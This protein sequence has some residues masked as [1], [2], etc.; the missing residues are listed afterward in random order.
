MFVVCFSLN[1]LQIH[2][3]HSNLTG[4]VD[5]FQCHVCN[6]SYYCSAGVRYPCP[7]NSLAIE[8]ADQLQEC[9]CNPGYVAVG[10]GP[11]RQ[12][13]PTFTYDF[14]SSLFPACRHCPNDAQFPFPQYAFDMPLRLKLWLDYAASIGATTNINAIGSRVGNYDD[15]GFTGVYA[16]GQATPP[17][18][19]FFRLR[20]SREY[21]RVTVIY[22]AFKQYI[23]LYI[24]DVLQQS[25]GSPQINSWSTPV[26]QECIYTTAYSPGSILELRG[27]GDVVFIGENLKFLF[28]HPQIPFACDLGLSPHWYLYGQ[29]NTCPANK[30]VVA[31][32]S[33]SVEDCVCLPGY[34]SQGPSV[35]TACLPCPADTYTKGSN[36]SQCT[37]CPGNSS[38]TSTMQTDISACLCNAGWAGIAATGCN[39]CHVDF[40]SDRNSLNC[41]HCPPGTATYE[42]PRASCQ[43]HAGY[44]PAYQVTN[45]ATRWYSATSESNIVQLRGEL[46]SPPAL[47][48]PWGYPNNKIYLSYGWFACDACWCGGGACAW[49]IIDL[50]KIE[51]VAGFVIQHSCDGGTKCGQYVNRVQVQYSVVQDSGFIT[52][53][54]S[55]DGGVDFYPNNHAAK[56]YKNT[57]DKTYQ[58]FASPVRARYIRLNPMLPGVYNSAFF[59]SGVIIWPNLECSSCRMNT[60]KNYTGTRSVSYDRTALSECQSCPY[61]SSTTATNSTSCSCNAGAYTDTNSSDASVCRGCGLGMYLSNSTCNNC[62]DNTFASEVNTQMCTQC[63]NASFNHDHSRSFCLCKSGFISDIV[64]VNPPDNMRYFSQELLGAY[65]GIQYSESRL[66]TIG[67]QAGWWPALHSNAP[68]GTWLAMDLGVVRRVYGVVIQSPDNTGGCGGSLVCPTAISVEYSHFRDTGF[69][70]AKNLAT[71]NTMFYPVDIGET[72]ECLA[73][74]G[75][76]CAKRRSNNIFMEPVMTRYV[77]IRVWNWVYRI[78]M[79]AGVLVVSDTCSPCPAN[80]YKEY[81][82]TSG[83]TCDACQPN[84]VSHPGS[85][86]QSQCNCSAG[87]FKNGSTL[88]PSCAGGYYS[89][90]QDVP[91]CTKCPEHTF[92]DPAL[93]P[94]DTASDCRV[95]KLCNTSTNAAFTDHYDAARG[96][97]GCG[98]SSVEVCTQCPSRSSLFLP[99]TESQRNLGVSSC[100]CDADFY[101]NVGT[102]CTACPANQV[103]PNLTNVNTTLADCLCTAGFEPNASAANLCTLCPVGSYKPYTGDDMCTACAPTFTTSKVGTNNASGCVCQPGYVYGNDQ[104]TICPENM[105]KA[106]FNLDTTCNACTANSFGPAGGTVPWDCSCS[107]NHEANPLLC[108]PCKTGKYKN[109]STTIGLSNQLFV[110]SQIKNLARTCSGGP[111]PTQANGYWDGETRFHPDRAVDGDISEYN[112]FLSSPQHIGSWL[113]I[114]MQQSVSVTMVRIYNRKSC[115][116][117]CLNNF[118]IR[119]GDLTFNKQNIAQN[120]ACVT[121]GPHFVDVKD[122]PCVLK[123]RWFT[124]QIFTECGLGIRE[125]EIYGTKEAYTYESANEWKTDV[126]ST[127]TVLGRCSACPQNTATNNTGVLACEACAAGK[128]TDRR[129]G[130]VECVC[131]VGTEHGTDGECVTCPAGRYK[132]TSTDKYAN[133]ACVNCSSCAANQ[134]VATLCNATH[135]V[136]CR[137]CQANS[138]SYAGRTELG[139]CLCNAGYELQGV[140]CVACAV[141]KARQVNNSNSIVCETCGAG[142]FT[143]VSA[144]ITCGVCSDICDKPC[145]EKIFDFSPYYGVAAWKAAA[146]AWG[147][148]HRLF[149]QSGDGFGVAGPSQAGWVQFGLPGNSPPFNNLEVSFYSTGDGNAL[150]Y[151]DDQLKASAGAYGSSMFPTVY[152]QVG[153]ITGTLKLLESGSGGIGRALKITLRRNCESYVKN[154]CNASRDVIC[155]ECQTCGLGFYANNTCGVNHS[156]DRLDTQCAACPAGY[157]CPGGRVAISC[158]DNRCAANQQVAT[159]CNTTH[160]VTCKACQANSWSYAGRTE[161]GPC[162]CNAGYELQGVL[163]IACPVG[164]AR[165]ANANNSIVCE[166]CA[167]GTFTSVSANITCSTCSKCAGNQQV[168]TLCNATHNVTCK[169][170]QANSWSYAGSTE[171]GP[172]LCNAGY[173]LQGVLCIACPVGK[174]RQ[175]NYN[176]SIMCET[177]ASGTLTT[178]TATT[179][180][181]SCSANCELNIPL[182]KK[183]ADFTGTYSTT[184]YYSTTFSGDSRISWLAYANSIGA[185]YFNINGEG[186]GGVF[187]NFGASGITLGYIEFTLPSGYSFVEIDA[188][189]RGTQELYISGVRYACNSQ[190]KVIA[191]YI[192]GDK[193]RFSEEWGVITYAIK[194]SVFRLPSLPNYVQQE[195]NA[196]RDVICQECQTCGVG[197]FANNTCGANYSNGR[198]DTQCAVC[199]AGS[200]C[201]TGLGPPI[202]CPNNGQSLPGS[203]SDDACDCDPGYFR[204]VDGCKQC[205]L[206]TYCPGEQVQHAISCPPMSRTIARGSTMRMDCHCQVGYFRDPPS[207]ENSFNCSLCLPGDFCFNNSAYNCSDELMHSEP[208]S[209]FVDNCTCVSGYY[210][211]GSRCENCPGGYF[212]ENGLLLGCAENEWTAGQERVDVCLCK[213]GFYRPN[214]SD[215]CVPCTDNYFCDGTDDAQHACPANAVSHSATHVQDCLCDV[216]FQAIFSSN[217][218]EPHSCQKCL[219]SETFKSSV[220]NTACTPCS[221]CL[222]QTHSTW[223]Q[224]VCT[225]AEDSLCDTCSVCHNTSLLEVQPRARSEYATH[226]CQQFFDTRCGNC[227]TCNASEWE[228]T[229]CSETEDAICAP[230]NYGRQCPVGF[231][232]GGDTYYTD[233]KCLPCTVRNMPYQGMWLHEFTSAGAR[234]NDSLSC[235][236]KCLPFSRL[237]KNS[238]SSFGCT[239]CETGNV[240]F[241]KFTQH[242]LE[243]KFECLHGYVV[244]NGDCV[245]GPMSADENTFWNHSLNVTHVQREEQHNNSGSGAFFVTVSHTAHGR[246]AVV[247]G[248]SEPTCSG[249]ARVELRAPSRAACCFSELW[250]V[251]TRSQLGLASTA[252]ELCS[253]QHPPWSELRSNTQLAFEVSDKR[254]EEL[255]NCSQV[256]D[257]L[258]CSLYVSI[259]DTKLVHHFSVL[260][261]LQLKRAGA[262]SAVG[263]QTY[264][265]L[266]RVRV[267]V[268]LAY[269]EVDG[270]HVFVVNSDLKPLPGAGETEVELVGT[271]LVPIQI[272]PE[273]NCSRMFASKNRN[274]TSNTWALEGEGPYVTTFFRDLRSSELIHDTRFIKLFYTIRLRERE[275]E[276]S[277]TI[278]NSTVV[279]NIMHVAVWRNVSTTQAVCVQV[280]E[281]H[282]Q[283]STG[284][285]VSCSGLG[286]DA[287]ASATRLLE[288]TDTVHGAVGGLTS[289]VAMSTH[290]HVRSVNIVSMLLAFA[291]PPTL[292]PA[293]TTHMHMGV[294]DFTEDFRS[295]CLQTPLCHF[296]HAY[297]G[298][299]K[300]HFMTSCDSASQDAARAWLTVSLGVVHDA[301]HVMALCNI[302]ARQSPPHY[303]FL[304]TLV[305]T[306]AFLPKSSQWHDLQNHSAPVS[307]S[308]VFALFDFV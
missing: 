102:A 64:E 172:C 233:S 158:A 268:Q 12:I 4:D 166:T 29:R 78:A 207:A 252:P 25:C 27:N 241:K 20:L 84:S 58:L 234:Y 6:A 180:C 55:Y 135:D 292:I 201:P 306:R 80:T 89:L 73:R 293:N 300:I 235:E 157:H 85:V 37:P 61:L 229:P 143:S 119:L 231:Y 170:C 251:S 141:G 155:Q 43:C 149:E 295:A 262:L 162:L 258:S 39:E 138:W 75:C 82:G 187:G 17:N 254:I 51:S 150:L 45:G 105:Y 13:P 247:V 34:A 41:T 2:A 269:K 193:V 208:G 161:L 111:C 169:A 79:R 238:D 274:V 288:P 107:A 94:W 287:V 198:L 195:C 188:P 50:G 192:P 244:L 66:D 65:S 30:G 91:E 47:Y 182:V 210:N 224:I 232:A 245:L 200:Y 215:L 15:F 74:L 173:D 125:V 203:I 97:L 113:M 228:L 239:T 40:Y 59:R 18:A 284:N 176:N 36:S 136:T 256:Q 179:V 122:F 279:K 95:C 23:H 225:P 114:D 38:H 54:S 220:G 83:L 88:C 147:M 46:D 185:T 5:S 14:Y 177:C 142:T 250:R 31:N 236:L 230:I 271:G 1:F 144:S 219:N 60:F 96:G 118:E 221:V 146:E 76:A 213:P 211:N 301:A 277:S 160:N 130:Q 196:S 86:S 246:F 33:A 305:N 270:T 108:A 9:I 294:L 303:A 206:D 93:H 99:T 217:M 28:T 11:P 63:N 10:E 8:Y 110:A 117:E 222:P 298:L 132:A 171:L 52:A 152:K 199:P 16:N 257:G 116:H 120:P 168:A 123:G 240:L 184:D 261:Y 248:K 290:A 278:M 129:T 148:T 190:C 205:F 24:N 53:K 72:Q 286:H 68:A 263:T 302:V 297:Q 167:V 249:R 77:K 124:L 7:P 42:Y 127:G 273:V 216:S 209:G 62:L 189:G 174:A 35:Y 153:V 194:I 121:N 280:Q 289:F 140:L 186:W 291:L 104:C 106:G 164:K 133:R 218:S 67:S 264:V 115:C 92:T 48:S 299:Q 259:V 154:E 212:C 159:L 44:E 202:P 56:P 26:P 276:S 266:D 181:R 253:R 265:P 87:S 283:V 90:T 307:T 260:V 243:C 22:K 227:S 282:L 128:T 237:A 304:I 267:E 151:I 69:V 183:I 112:T 70:N 101:G 242:L 19:L 134:Q 204:D 126:V 49:T 223:T 139:P 255:A 197:F 272:S 285:V 156:N 21:T 131:D 214:S 308:K 281:K 98:G 109:E 178:Q 226:A 32:R 175:A 103:R 100:V 191:P 165:Q 3:L 275:T 163:C 57:F 71:G 296:Q 145:A 81:A 137:A